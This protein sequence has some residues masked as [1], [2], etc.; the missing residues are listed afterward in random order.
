[1]TAAQLSLPAD[2]RGDLIAPLSLQQARFWLVDQLSPGN[3]ASNIAVRW[4]LL[5][6][7]NVAIL[8]RAI[9]A[10]VRRHDVMRTH[11][12]LKDG[13]PM[14]IIQPDLAFELSVI[15]LENL[16]PAALNA[17]VERA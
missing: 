14:Q 5:G 17:E 15:D 10:V 13:E 4:K 7:L 3:A 11:V 16:A 12:E 2:H 8:E 6:P 9:A 1:M